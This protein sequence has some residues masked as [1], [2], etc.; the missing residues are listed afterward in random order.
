MDGEGRIISSGVSPRLGEAGTESTFLDTSSPSGLLSRLF[1]DLT[2]KNDPKLAVNP[3]GLAPLLLIP[4]DSIVEEDSFPTK[5]GLVNP[6]MLSLELVS[7]AVNCGCGGVE[8][9][10]D[11]SEADEV[12]EDEEEN[13]ARTLRE[14]R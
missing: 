14:G 13:L 1:R 5:A 10:I 2:L 3:L 9:E 7:L 12:V 11:D 4:P 8:P 6:V